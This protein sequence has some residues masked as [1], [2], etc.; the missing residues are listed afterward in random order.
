MFCPFLTLVYLRGE[1]ELRGILKTT[2]FS[3]LQMFPVGQ[4]LGSNLG[5][6]LANLE[7]LGGIQAKYFIS[8]GNNL[9]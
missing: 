5:S 2:N 8:L 7:V 6:A 1:R 9:F 3:C 4:R